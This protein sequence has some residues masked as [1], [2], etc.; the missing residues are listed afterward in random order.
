MDGLHTGL[1]RAR[2]LAPSA[3]GRVLSSAEVGGSLP[4]RA[5]F[6]LHGVGATDPHDEQ[7]IEA[8]ARA[9]C[10]LVEDQ[11]SGIAGLIQAT[12]GLANSLKLKQLLI[13]VKPN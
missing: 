9:V 1:P 10:D 4:L 8:A 2:V 6:D 12:M 7:G 11:V 5:W 3:N 13:Q